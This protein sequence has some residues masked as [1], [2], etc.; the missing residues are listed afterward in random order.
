MT[1]IYF[2]NVKP[3]GKNTWS[4]QL[5]IAGWIWSWFANGK[6]VCESKHTSVHVIHFFS[7]SN[8]YIISH[9]HT[10]QNSM[11][12]CT[13]K[14]IPP[15]SRFVLHFELYISF[16]M[17]VY[18]MQCVCWYWQHLH[19]IY[20]NT[21]IFCFYCHCDTFNNRN[22]WLNAR[23][24]WLFVARPEAFY[25]RRLLTHKTET[26]VNYWRHFKFEKKKFSMWKIYP[27]PSFCSQYK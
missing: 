27:S 11:T 23:N 20:T 15:I 16:Q 24:M 18:Y 4:K 1:A 5:Q 12:Y 3:T 22:N 8:F 7:R 9:V 19:T 25:L 26:I 2:G 17:Y 13:S 14:S 6:L 10:A 21:I